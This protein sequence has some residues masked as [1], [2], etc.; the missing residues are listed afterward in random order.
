M[1]HFWTIALLFVAAAAVADEVK[2]T[3]SGSAGL[4]GTATIVNKIQ[5]DGSKYIQL[6]MELRSMTGQIVNV[7]Q[8]SVY[9]KTGRPVRKIQTTDTKGGARQEIVAIFERGEVRV[10]STQDGKTT[11]SSVYIPMGK[12]I[13]AKSEFWFVRDKVPAGGKSTYMRF[14]LMTSKWVE[15]TAVYKGTREIRVGGKRVT[16]HLVEMGEVKAYV[17]DKGD[18]WRLELEGILLERVTK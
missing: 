1:R 10:R 3:I 14:D 5:K 7:L 18:P 15:E 6:S 9:D 16:A 12:N 4:K 2:M 8:E 13:N 11:R 17:D